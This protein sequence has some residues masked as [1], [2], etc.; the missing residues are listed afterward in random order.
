LV[1]VL[2]LVL[3]LLVLVLLLMLLVLVSTALLLV[4]EKAGVEVSVGW[5][6]MTEAVLRGGGGRV[7][8]IEGEAAVRALMGVRWMMRERGRWF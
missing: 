5:E 7:V 6:G 3:M 2:L 8:V 4:A 1:T